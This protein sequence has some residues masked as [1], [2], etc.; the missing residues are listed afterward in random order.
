M[1]AWITDRIV[2]KYIV[3]FRR[4][5][6]FVSNTLLDKTHR[7][8]QMT[9]LEKVFDEE[10]GIKVGA[11]VNWYR[12]TSDDFREQGFVLVLV[13]S[14]SVS[15]LANVLMIVRRGLLFY[16][17]R[18]KIGATNDGT[19]YTIVS[20]SRSSIIARFVACCFDG[21][22]VAILSVEGM[23]LSE[24]TRVSLGQLELM[25][26]S[27]G[28]ESATVIRYVELSS[29]N[30]D[31]FFFPGAENAGKLLNGPRDVK[32]AG[33]DA[34]SIQYRMEGSQCCFNATH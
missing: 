8:K 34:H 23:K 15:R 4:A 5:E 1:S 25:F 6:N 32:M 16:A 7:V 14:Y 18:V 31:C 27:Q 24:Y 21:D 11:P 3:A 26:K 12:W 28:G 22:T 19:E 10:T 30:N 13:L 33:E 17:N 9:E 2:Q 20:R 29:S